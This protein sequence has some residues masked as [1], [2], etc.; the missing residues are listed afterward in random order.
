VVLIAG[1]D[2]R[3]IDDGMGWTCRFVD[4]GGAELVTGSVNNGKE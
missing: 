4:G 1:W 3:V 2:C